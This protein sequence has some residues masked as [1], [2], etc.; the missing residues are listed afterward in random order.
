MYI[1]DIIKARSI[2]FESGRVHVV[3]QTHPKNLAQA[4]AEG[5]K[6][7]R[8]MKKSVRVGVNVA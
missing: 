8:I 7:P 6:N 4:K 3:G 1:I 5:E 2:V